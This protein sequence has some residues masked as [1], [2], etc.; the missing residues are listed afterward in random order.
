MKL[1]NGFICEFKKEIWV[2]RK[3]L[4]KKLFRLKAEVPNIM[5]LKKLNYGLMNG[6][7]EEIS[8]YGR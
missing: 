8:S 3:F 5:E 4:Q 1:N 7:Q 2:F 6:I